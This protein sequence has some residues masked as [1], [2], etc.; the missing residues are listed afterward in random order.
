LKSLR[1]ISAQTRKARPVWSG[2]DLLTRHHF[3]AKS[4][5]K[6]SGKATLYRIVNGVSQT[7]QSFTALNFE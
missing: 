2:L 1:Q 4:D 5:Q 6:S 7:A 3:L